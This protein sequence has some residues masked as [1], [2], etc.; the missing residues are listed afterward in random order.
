M[1]KKNHL[2]ILKDVG[3]KRHLIKCQHPLWIKLSAT[4]ERKG[5]N[6]IQI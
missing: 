5:L 4:L 1:I 6:T 2:I 3:E